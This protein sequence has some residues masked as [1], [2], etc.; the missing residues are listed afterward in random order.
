MENLGDL[1]SLS[2]ILAIFRSATPLIL[3]AIAGYYSERSGIAQIGLEGM[4]L[5][6]AL[7]GAITAY[8]FQSAWLGLLF[9]TLFG[10]LL[11]QLFSF[12]VLNLRTNHI[13]TGT[14]LNI[15]I[16]GLA[17]LITKYFFDSTGSTPTLDLS[18]RFTYEPM[19]L[20][21]IALILTYYISRHT[22]AGLLIQFAGENSAALSAAGYSAKKIRWFALSICGVLAACAGA[23]LSLFLS[24]SYSPLMTSGRGFI[25]LA[26]LILGGWKPIPTFLACLFFAF[27]DQLQMRMQGSDSLIPVQFVQILPYFLT[28]VTLILLWKTAKPPAEIAKE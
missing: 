9:A 11:S 12:F 18:I 17:P 19:L 2:F 22:K 13:V 23:S 24:S 15:L 26:A 4:M 8:Y 6:G 1:I 28:I 27:T 14:A 21:I 16:V 10:F 20:A 5:F 25:A 3:A 7:T